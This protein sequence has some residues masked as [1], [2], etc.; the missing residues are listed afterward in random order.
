MPAPPP[1]ADCAD[2]RAHAAV[3]VV[4]A[5]PG[6]LWAMRIALP[7]ESR[8]RLRPLAAIA[9][10][11]AAGL[12][13]CSKPPPPPPPPAPPPPAPVA[14]EP[15]PDA[16]YCAK[17]E[18]KTAFDIA[19]LKTRLMVAALACGDSDKYNA[20]IMQNRPGLVAQEKT[21]ATWFARNYG[22][23]AADE[24][25]DYIT[26]L[27]NAQSLHRIRDAAKF[28]T[29]SEALFGQ[30]ATVKAAPDLVLLATSTTLTQP[31]NVHTCEQQTADSKPA[32]TRK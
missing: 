15:V 24:H 19:A 27:A 10:L 32:K 11:L 29:E 22:K 31:M 17:P 23:K 7:M 12:A 14:E 8:M 16:P 3:A 26:A 25:D 20:F 18:E 9:M 1:S 4:V 30:I 6:A 28:C 5:T 21:L 2:S 13:G